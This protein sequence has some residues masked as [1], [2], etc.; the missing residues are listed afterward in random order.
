MPTNEAQIASGKPSEAKAVDRIQEP[1]VLPSDT[2]S[3]KIEMSAFHWHLLLKDIEDHLRI[4]NRDWKTTAMLYEMI[5][6]QLLGGKVTYVVE[7]ECFDPKVEEK[8]PSQTEKPRNWWA[9]IIHRQNTAISR[10]G[11]KEPK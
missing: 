1:I 4:V 3:I 5:S 6:S 8:A 7:K 10:D 2:P 11:G 9:R